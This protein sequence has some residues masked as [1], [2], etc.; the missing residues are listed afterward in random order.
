MPWM[1]K[2][3][4]KDWFHPV[5]GN[6]AIGAGTPTWMPIMPALKWCLNCRAAQPLR[7]DR[8]PVAI[9]AVLADRQRLLQVAGADDREHRAEDLLAG[10]AHARL[11]PVQ[12][13]RADQEA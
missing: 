2:S 6:H 1:C 4:K 12:D 3:P 5:N 10:H 11:D 9:G 7:E 8:R 13:A